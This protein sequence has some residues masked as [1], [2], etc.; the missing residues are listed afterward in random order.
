MSW[1]LWAGHAGWRMIEVS[2]VAVCVSTLHHIT[3]TFDWLELMD[4]GVETMLQDSCK[5]YIQLIVYMFYT[6]L[7]QLN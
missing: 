5:L 6:H 3:L 1:L 4:Q 2:G 7:Y